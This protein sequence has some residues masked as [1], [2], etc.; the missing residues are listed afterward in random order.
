MLKKTFIYD[1]NA[2]KRIFPLI[3]LEKINNII[4]NTPS[5]SDIRKEFYKKIIN[6]RYNKI[7]KYSINKLNY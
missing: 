3:N 1:N 6:E 2:L 4:D 7:L 5:I